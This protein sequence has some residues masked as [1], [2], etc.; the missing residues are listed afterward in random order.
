M[1]EHDPYS[2]DPSKVQE[3]PTGLVGCLKYIGPGFILSASIVGS[4]EL[5]ATTI[6]G[7][8]AG[9]VL[10]W[11]IIFSC[12]VKVAVQLEFGKHAIST[13]ESTMA[14]LNLLPGPRIGSANW[15]IWTWLLLMSAKM[16]QVGGIVGGVVMAL[17]QMFP[18]LAPAVPDA[19]SA[20]QV[21]TTYAVAA[22]VSLIVFRGYYRVIE[23][24][25][26]VMIGLF[27]V[28]TV[29]S[30]VAL[31]WTDKA[32]QPN[33]LASGLIPNVPSQI[34]VIAPSSG[35]DGTFTVSEIHVE[36]GSDIDENQELFTLVN[37]NGETFAIHSHAAGT[38]GEVKVGLGDEVSVGTVVATIGTSALIFVA[39]GAFGITGVGGDEIMAYNYWLIEKGYAA[40]VGPKEDTAGW[41]HRAKGW[42]RIMYLD[43]ILSM[44]AYTLMT[45]MFYLLG[46][47]V[48]NRMGEI[49]ESNQLIS[50]LS[51]MYTETLG[52]GAR[53]IFLIGA[54]VV[55]YST[56]MA[57]LA[58]W[59]RLFSD[60][61]GRIGLYS[62]EEWAARKRAIAIFAWVIPA[63]WG[64]LFLTFKAPGW[65]VLIGGVATTI[66]L[67][68]VVF[69]AVV[70]RYSRLDRRLV[71]TKLYDL[72]LWLSVISILIVAISGIL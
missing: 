8:E 41:L 59:S 42:I 43:A 69:A 68:I 12:I 30:L 29:A 19:T 47:A 15:S 40:Y 28:F 23:K 6:L 16:L 44:I 20:V 65:M 53:F 48:L 72:C 25:A 64:T 45:A 3:P 5:I 18:V 52:P 37:E 67:L 21:L 62:F 10:L 60:A 1:T 27:T 63:I 55:L 31:Q 2:L 14:S 50:T 49:P 38:V 39:I 13:G 22:S 32:I 9:F 35:K 11:F 34:D 46:A 58:A 71:P 26:L 70:F 36:G 33:E 17:E 61:F 57:A 51:T 24:A 66:I 4:G 56:L 54:I 7:A